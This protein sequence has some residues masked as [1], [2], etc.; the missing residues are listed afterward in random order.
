MKTKDRKISALSPGESDFWSDPNRTIGPLR[1]GRVERGG[2]LTGR[3]GTGE[4]FL[5]G[6]EAHRPNLDGTGR[7]PENHSKGVI[8]AQAGIHRDVGPRLPGATPFRGLHPSSSVTGSTFK[9]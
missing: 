7:S 9:P 4:G 3:A 2:A 8:P 5:P 6:E 1:S